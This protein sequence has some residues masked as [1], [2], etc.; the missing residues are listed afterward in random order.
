MLKRKT[1]KDNLFLSV[2]T[3]IRKNW[4]NYVKIPYR[5]HID[6]ISMRTTAL[7]ISLPTW[8][9]YSN[10]CATN[11]NSNISPVQN[12]IHSHIRTYVRMQTTMM[13]MRENELSNCDN[14]HDDDNASAVAHR[15]VNKHFSRASRFNSHHI[16]LLFTKY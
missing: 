11:I 6:N 13:M 7:R 1:I 2:H 16:S 4:K 5:N 15:R 3:S 12:Y 9:I 8:I 10:E 14:Q